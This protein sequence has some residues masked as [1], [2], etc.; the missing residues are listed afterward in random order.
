MFRKLDE[1]LQK[2][3]VLSCGIAVTTVEEVFIKVAI[4]SDEDQQHTLQN[5]VKQHAVSTQNS[6]PI[7][8]NK[9]GDGHYHELDHPGSSLPLG[10]SR[11][12][13]LS[14][15]VAMIQKLFRMAKREKKLF[16]VAYISFTAVLFIVIAFAYYPASIVV[17]LVR[18]R[19]PDHNSKHQQL[20]SGVG[21][22][23][24]WTANYIWNFIVDPASSQTYMILINFV[25]GLALMVIYFIMQ[26]PLF[27]LGRG[28]LNLT[29]V[30][31]THTGGAKTDNGLSKGPFALENTG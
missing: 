30:E 22:N 4:A 9:T 10:R 15:T 31:I 14:Q 18:E 28:L 27:R 5:G 29:I 6:F 7:V 25:L 1:N 2:L 12:V 19:S 8:G 23:S 21:I 16:V 24:F 20:V 13:F 26:S 3:Q 11:S 17:M